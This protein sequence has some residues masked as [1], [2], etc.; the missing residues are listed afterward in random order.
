MFQGMEDAMRALTKNWG[1]F[2]LRGL[3]AIIF[4]ILIVI[5]PSTS[6]LALVIFFGAYVLVE[7]IFLLIISA[8]FKGG[9]G[10]RAWIIFS[11]IV[12]IA[13][14]IMT[15]VWPGIT[16][17]VLLY[18]IAIW[19]LITGIFQLIFAFVIPINT[20][21]RMLLGLAGAFS[22]ILGIF[23]VARPGQGAL[24]VVWI[25]GLFAVMFGVYQIAVGIFLKALRPENP[26]EDLS[27]S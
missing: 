21:N 7:G 19:A 23:L 6:I 8:A 27:P 1:L 13:A 24:T 4:G 17:V 22:I 26:S 20:G 12:G 14:G 15:F 5:W 3:L 2:T 9:G 18:I 25:I 10:D 11:G 16:A